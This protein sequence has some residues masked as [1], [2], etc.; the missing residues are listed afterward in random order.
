MTTLSFGKWQLGVTDQA[1]RMD[2]VIKVVARQRVKAD[3]IDQFLAYGRELVAASRNDAGNIEYSLNRSV[4]D[5]QVFCYIEVWESKEALEA[6]MAA[7]HF[8]RLVPL[9]S[10]LVEEDSKQMDVFTEI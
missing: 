4:T 1:E 9:T 6:H 10:A 7:E 2:A 8:K 5:P 3:M